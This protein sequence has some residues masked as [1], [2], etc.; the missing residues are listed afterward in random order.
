MIRKAPTLRA[1]YRT[2]ALVANV[3]KPAV[4]A[5]A[6]KLMEIF[7]RFGVRA[8][9][10]PEVKK[11]FKGFSLLQAAPFS[12]IAEGSDM[13]L[14]LGGDGTM[15]S[16][17]SLAV[18]EGIPVLGVNLGNLGFITPVSLE[19]F[20]SSLSDSLR[21]LYKIQRRSMLRAR[22]TRR[23]KLVS[24]RIALNDVVILR[25]ATAKVAL[26]ETRINGKYLATYKADGLIVAT[27]TG[28]TAYSLAVGGPILD[29]AVQNIVLAPICPHTLSARPLV[30]ADS[31][32]I[33]ILV[34]KTHA[35]LNFSTDGEPGFWL[36]K[37]D[38]LTVTRARQS[39][40]L[41]V[42]PGYDA[43]EV[44]RSKLGWLGR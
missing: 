12:R 1:K 17:A 40:Q 38:K 26:L 44:L 42:P 11:T 25:G 22:I 39:V 31:S 33:E 29:T 36:Q 7:G 30:L 35:R 18:A 16:A 15:L 9:A 13:V 34:P 8:R 14:S 24:D 32:V 2:V 10:V 20:E 21:G 27:P 43:W 23:G 3:G 4:R 19:S 5:L 41:L 37:G 6:P 28:S